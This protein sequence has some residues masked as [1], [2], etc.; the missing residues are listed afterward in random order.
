MAKTKFLL[1]PILV[2]SLA[3]L[4]TW[5]QRQWSTRPA[6]TP[7]TIQ[8]EGGSR[9]EFRDFASSALGEQTPYSIL[10]PPAYDLEPDRRFPVI[11]FLHGMNN[12]HVRWTQ[13]QYDNIPLAIESLFLNHNVPQFLMVHPY[14][15][16]PFF[17]DYEDGSWNGEEYIYKD[18][19]QEIEKYFRVKAGR[20]NRVIGGTSLG[21]FAALKIAMKYPDLYSSVAAGSP[22][23]LLGDDPSKLLNAS[24]GGAVRRFSGLFN[25]VFGTPFNQDHWLK[26][27][28]EVLA[29][30]ADLK[31]LRVYLSYGTADRYEA[32]FP[33]R[34]AIQILH[35]IL[36]DRGVSSVFQVLEG[37]PHGWA[38]IR[39][40]LEG[41]I[42]F[43][44]QTF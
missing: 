3:S 30:S 29:R 10:L 16:N 13:Q 38:L 2:L 26:N 31:D 36:T 7:Q 22:I 33:M 34:Q 39:A 1:L 32:F 28:V 19:I 27:S 23:I 42:E 4:S 9:V 11:Y 20:A 18:L 14:G 5:G 15:K 8:L 44:T 12:N 17:T 41:S 21:G 24:S 40:D 37:E 35:Q 6:E 43:L 25:P